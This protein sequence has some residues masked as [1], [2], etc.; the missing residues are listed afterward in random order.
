M[1]K[2]SYSKDWKSAV[3]RALFF[4]V[5]AVVI[6][7]FPKGGKFKYQFSE[8]KPWRYE[9]LTASFDF[10]IYK[11]NDLLEKERDSVMTNYFK[12][13]GEVAEGADCQTEGGLR[14]DPSLQILARDDALC[15]DMP[16]GG[17]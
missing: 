5:V 10:P 1:D 4:L 13:N 7:L 9:L 17:V 12:L 6:L 14:I 3:V 11:S 16:T 2:R 15:G 8:G